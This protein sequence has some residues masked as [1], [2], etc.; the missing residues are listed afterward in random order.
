MLWRIKGKHQQS[1][2]KI[3]TQL[4]KIEWRDPQKITRQPVSLEL[5]PIIY[6]YSKLIRWITHATGDSPVFFMERRD[7]K[8]THF[9]VPS[10]WAMESRVLE[11][12]ICK[13]MTSFHDNP[14][15]Q[16][17]KQI[18]RVVELPR[19]HT[20]DRTATMHYFG[21]PRHLVLVNGT[22]SRYIRI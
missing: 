11:L 4:L 9:I 2:M 21:I 8:F 15:P 19:S 14:S 20:G 1:W 5:K 7:R 12:I 18:C 3:P 22:G 6:M 10:H 16:T 13:L 17:A